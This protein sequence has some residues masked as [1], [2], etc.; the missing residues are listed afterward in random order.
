MKTQIRASLALSILALIVAVAAGAVGGA[1]A[2]GVIITTKQIK[3]NTITSKDLKNGAA[4]KSTD[5]TNGTVASADIGNGDV[6]SADI[7]EGE[8]HTGDIGANAVTPAD[9]QLPPPVQETEGI[10]SPQP[11]VEGAFSKIAT[12]TTYSKVQAESTLEVSWSG[13]VASGT[14]TNCVYQLRVNGASPVGGG[15]E[16][17]ATGSAVNVSTTAAFAGLPVG[18][19]TI[20]VWAK[21]SAA[22]S[23][24]PTCVIDPPNPGIESTFVIAEAIV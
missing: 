8:V 17:F 11:V 14:G 24:T 23:A 21:A 15:G 16:V 9:V 22:L 20:E 6:A 13:A 18:P 4:V 7:G 12:I 10:G 3:N 19:A 1:I 2:S 5:I